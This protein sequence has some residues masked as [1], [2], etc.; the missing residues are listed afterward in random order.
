MNTATTW[1]RCLLAS[2]AFVVL[3]MTA[4]AADAAKKRPNILFI[5]TDDQSHRTVSCY[6]E[7]YPW[8]KTPNI[9]ALAQRGVRCTHAYIGT[10]CMPSRATMLTGHHPYGVE[11]MRLEGPYPGSTYDPA[12]CPF[13]PKVFRQNGYV[14]AH[15][16]KWHTG[17]DT[18]QG[19]DW[20][21]Q[22]VW[23]RPK[24]TDNATNYYYNQMITFNGGETKLV[25]DYSTDNYT[26]WANEFIRGKGRDKDKPW[27]LWLCYGAVHGPY[28]P[29]KRHQDELKDIKVPTPAGIY[30]PRP[31]KPDYVQKLDNFTKGEDGQPI[32]KGSG[33]NI[34]GTNTLTDWVR[35]YHQG[36]LAIDEGVAEL[37]KTL[38]ETGQYENT[39]IVYTSD[40]GYA[41]GQHGFIH[42]LAPYDATIRCPLIFHMPGTLPEGAVCEHPVGG[43]DL[44]PTFFQFAG[45]DLP[46]K[47]H[48]HDLTPLLKNPKMDWPHPVLMT[49]T[50]GNYG[51]AT[52]QIPKDGKEFFRGQGI[53]WWVSLCQGK[54]KYI[55]TLMENEIEELYDLQKDPEELNNLALNPK[56]ADKLAEMREAAIAEMRRTDA[57][58]LDNLPPVKMAAK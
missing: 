4:Q 34:F 8:V 9:D 50:G 51:S 30:P 39:L 41:W 35:Q 11:S 37:V 49:L 56:Y 15:I 43:V 33:K 44:I 58:W 55:R 54:Y 7:A 16:G 1:T 13:W 19:R 32:R 21:Y 45:I 24:Y 22:I 40:Q 27:Y 18:G 6:P 36:V 5:Y 28:T 25:K 48:G 46:W 52:H 31:G 29:A 2:L 47:M 57:G 42:K 38:K 10:W 23:N 3:G 20:D 17:T 53:P 26:R 12:Q 14:T